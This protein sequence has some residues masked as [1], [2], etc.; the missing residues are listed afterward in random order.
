MIYG[1]VESMSPLE[2]LFPPFLGLSLTVFTLVFA[3]LKLWVSLKLAM[4]IRVTKFWK[5]DRQPFLI[6]LYF[7]QSI[8]WLLSVR[9]SRLHRWQITVCWGTIAPIWDRRKKKPVC[10]FENAFCKLQG[11]F[12]ASGCINIFYSCQQC[13]YVGKCLPPAE[14]CWMQPLWWSSESA[15]FILTHIESY[16]IFLLNVVW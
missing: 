9:F 7:E 11:S 16:H 10:A 15:H 5:S 6:H 1:I 3:L 12:A 8:T 4:R 2:P 13:E 14:L